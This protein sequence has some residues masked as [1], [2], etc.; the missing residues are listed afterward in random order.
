MSEA[1]QQAL[2]HGDNSMTNAFILITTLL[3][4]DLGLSLWK[5]R[6]ERVDK[7]LDDVPTLIVE[8]GRPL[9]DRMDRE[10]VDESDVLAA[11]RAQRG[12]ERMEQ[13]KYAILERS[14]GITVIAK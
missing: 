4:L 10:R 9:K 12:L 7:L 1:A 3:G 13:I 14:G 6:S 8:D 2:I 11:A 5:Q